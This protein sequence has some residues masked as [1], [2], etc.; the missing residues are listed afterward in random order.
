MEW[1]TIEGYEQYEVSNEQG[2]VRNKKTG[3]IL[4]QWESRGYL[5]VRL[6]GDNGKKTCSVHRLVATA[7]IPNPNNLTDVNHIDENKLNN[8]VSNLEWL[9]H[10]NN[11]RHGTGITRRAKTRNRKVYC[12]ELDQTFNSITEASEETGVGCSHITECCQGIYKTAGEYH[13]KYVDES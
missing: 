5:Q 6:Y 8:S 13:W 2:L 4:K 3:R 7:F 9:S 12:V 1:K 10:G 11:V